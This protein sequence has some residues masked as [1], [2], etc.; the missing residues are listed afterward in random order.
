MRGMCLMPP[1]KAN[2]RL[3]SHTDARPYTPSSNGEFHNERAHEETAGV[4]PTKEGSQ[5]TAASLSDA[6]YVGTESTLSIDERALRRAQILDEMTA[7]AVAEGD[8][9]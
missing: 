5:S 4:T 1:R 7:D 6:S 8:Y 3:N 2:A 9:D